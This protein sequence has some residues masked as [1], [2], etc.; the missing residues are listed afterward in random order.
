MIK[1]GMLVCP[2]CKTSAMTVG[3]ANGF[4][5]DGCGRI[6]TKLNWNTPQPSDAI[7]SPFTARPDLKELYGRKE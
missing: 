4:R 6:S 3:L 7:Q 5:C 2:R 1:E